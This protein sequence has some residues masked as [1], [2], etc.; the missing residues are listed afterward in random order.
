MR[1]IDSRF[2]HGVIRRAFAVYGLAP[3]HLDYVA[4]SLVEASLRGIDTHGVR[5]TRTYLDELR[6]GRALAD[7]K[8]VEHSSAPA[9]VRLDAGNALGLVAA[10]VGTEIAIRQARSCG[11]AAVAI[12]N[13]NHF[14][15]AA[16]YPLRI[17]RAGMVGLCFSNADALVAPF[18][19]RSR[20]LGTNPLSFAAP[21]EG[22]EIYCLDMATSQVA[23]SKVRQ[24]IRDGRPLEKGWC[25]EG[26]HA[27]ENAIVL[28]PL[29]GY[30]G[31]GLALMVQIL[32]ALLSG[33]MFDHEMSHLYESKSPD[34][35]RVGHF[36]VAIDIAAFVHIGEFRARL[37]Q[38]LEDI[39]AC[40][41]EPG[42]E[43]MVAGDRARQT[44]RQ[45]SEHGIPVSEE[46]YDFF[47]TLHAGCAR[48]E[49]RRA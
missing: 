29:G 38:L 21:S 11:I 18:N 24:A 36:I 6:Y 13:S 33:M 8:M 5:L 48:T 26:G 25:V 16:L 22:E 2:L 12:A 41:N 49:M 27:D 43:I 9:A 31:Q 46:E 32:S 17:A 37:R 39:R 42:T 47:M 19:G 28:Q 15:A 30:K 45:R 40:D 34:P 3:L 10:N 35:R 44:F 20:M 7:P 23:Y 1:T 14:G 4:D